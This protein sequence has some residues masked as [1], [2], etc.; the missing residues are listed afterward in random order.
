V[1]KMPPRILFVSYTSDQTGPTVSLMLLLKHLRPSFEVAVA[2]PGTGAF[3]ARLVQQGIRVHCFRALGK[4]SI[5]ALLRVLSKGRYDMVYANDTSGACRNAMIAA[6]V[7]RLPFVSHV[8]SMLH[9]QP[10]SR[11]AYLR[12]A[13]AV[14]AVSKACALALPRFVPERRIHVVHNGVEIPEADADKTAAA[15]LSS[16]RLSLISV[17]HICR[18]KGQ[19]YIVAAMAHLAHEYPCLDLTLV[20]ALNREPAYVEELRTTVAHLGLNQRVHLAGFQDD[21]GDWLK[22]ADIFVH[23]ALADP[24]PRAVLEAMSLGLPVVAF[25][26]DGVEE[27]VIDGATG[28]LAP[29][30]DVPALTKGISRLVED[31]SLRQALGSSGRHHIA[32]HFQASE[33]ASRIGELIL[34]TLASRRARRRVSQ[35]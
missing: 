18:R 7:L 12:Y 29:P 23:T 17:S 11:L 5:P 32:R 25:A 16:G 26:V 28:F 9:N 14:I 27:T 2:L 19:S 15:K 34:Q 22:S 13:D 3:S 35:A 31:P 20:G 21:C 1:R 33:T 24:H 4:Y 30:G 8:R 6:K 10:L